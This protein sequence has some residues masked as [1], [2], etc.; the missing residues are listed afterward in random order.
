M[1]RPL[2]VLV[3]QDLRDA[4]AAGTI[5]A[6]QPIE[7]AQIQPASL[8]LRLGGVAHRVRA[9]FLPGSRRTVTER[10]AELR[11]H[12]LDLTAGAVLER[13]CV[14]IVPLV[15]RLD[16]PADLS[17]AA[18]PKSSTGRLDVFARVITD[19]GTAFDHVR[20]GYA[21]P[22]FAEIS[23]R[24]FSVLA[25]TGDRLAQLRLRRGGGAMTDADLNALQ[26]QLKLVDG[27]ADLPEAMDQ[28]LP[29]TV[30]LEGADSDGVIGYRARKH[31]GLIDLRRLNH[32][33][34]SDFWEPIHARPG[35]GLVLDPDDFY[36]LASRERVR[37]PPS[38]AAEMV[39]YDTMVGEFRV[40]YAG[41]F[42]PGFG[43]PDANGAGT[44]AVLEIRSHEVPFVIDE[45]QVVGRLVYE[46]LTD[47][48]DIL[49]GG[50]IGSNYQ[51][52]GLALA[53]HFQRPG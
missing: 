2:G 15:E 46:R 19:Q 33:A 47:T 22:L 20:E 43:D 53:K 12:S 21:G 52:Q 11:M 14:Y 25:R 50:S 28:G 6:E 36:I 41:F 29:L 1:T 31:A 38:H 17:A 27:D 7:A 30:D 45:G 9:S 32:Y 23:P 37:V 39:A 35:R 5:S 26:A 48:P 3:A 40:H 44:R 42:D 24:S 8:D 49:Y 34:V 4:I 51:R 10:I 13:G 16:L 18:N